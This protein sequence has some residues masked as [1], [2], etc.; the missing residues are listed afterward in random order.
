M[1][2]CKIE[3][4]ALKSF[5]LGPQAENREWVQKQIHQI[6]NAWFDWRSGFRPEDGTAIS[7]LDMAT[8]EYR[9]RIA[10]T[11]AVL[12]ELAAKFENEIPKFSPR[13]IGHMFS[14]ISLPALFG[15]ILTVLHNPNNIS[16]ESSKVGTVLEN[17]AIE[18]LGTMLGFTEATGHFTSGGTIANFEAVYRARARLYSWMSLGLAAGQ[19]RCFESASSGWE[20]AERLQKNIDPDEAALWNPLSSDPFAVATRIQRRTGMALR[21]P[22]ILVS[23]H[24][25]YSWVK[26]AH[27][28]GLGADALWPVQVTE[29]GTLDRVDLER[30]LLEASA[31]DRPVLM[32]VSVLGTTELGMIDPIA[33][34]QGLLDHYRTQQGWH[35][36]HHIDAAYGGFLSSMRGA[37]EEISTLFS[38][39]V[40]SDL[41][42]VKLAESVTLDP[43]KLG[44]VPYASGVFLCRDARDY[45][46]KPFGGPYVDFHLGID[47]GPF[48]I[49]G[50]RSATGAVAT[51]MTAQ[52]VGLNQQ[53]YGAIIA[54]TIRL[55]AE[56]E[57]KLREK[58]SDVRLAPS[59]D[60]NLLG[61]SL[62]R[63]GE[64]LTVSNQRTLEIFHQFSTDKRG[65]FFVSKTSLHRQNYRKYFEKFVGSWNGDI[66]T[67]ELV[68]IR[69]CVMN[70]F[71]KSQ[72]MNIQ[73]LD[74]FV[75]VLQ[76]LS[77]GRA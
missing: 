8:P 59:C 10:K 41:E 12:K 30:R 52:C 11:D 63:P 75:E 34:V 29:N 46:Q 32:V 16:Q 7:S 77:S 40:R 36:W 58:I 18:A 68:L 24:K 49:E 71:F 2:S 51:W 67:E 22:V 3:E 39:R 25:H 33:E 54:R 64:S 76:L 15:H 65:E 56:L 21:S 73:A 60:S 72:E 44:Y 47:K 74:R 37:D 23:Q 43:H 13:Y 35:I 9:A 14:E 1:K 5:F 62:A 53:G 38:E 66:D 50:S 27:L 26:A 61:F 6:L 45:F 57:T 31:Q 55:R 69:I 17:E 20:A 28:F 70:P 19:E 48:T 42:A 4:I